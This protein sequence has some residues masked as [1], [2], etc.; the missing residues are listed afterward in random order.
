MLACKSSFSRWIAVFLAV[1]FLSECAGGIPVLYSQTSAVGDKEAPT[2]NRIAQVHIKNDSSAKGHAVLSV[3][4]SKTIHPLSAGMRGANLGNWTFFWSRPYPNDSPK[5]RELTRLIKP[6]VLRYAGGLLSNDVTWDRKNTQCYPSRMKDGVWC[7]RRYYDPRWDGWD[8]SGKTPVV[9]PGAYRLGY[10][11]DEIDA[12]AKFAKYVGAEVMIEVNITTCD[13][14]LWADMVRYANLEHDYQFKYW[15]LGNELDLARAAGKSDAPVGKE[16]VSRFKMYCRAMKA[17]D[18]SIRLVGPATAAHEEDSYFRAFKDFIDPLTRDKEIRNKRM[19]DV[20]SYHHYPLWNGGG[21]NVGYKDMFNYLHPSENRSRKH[22]NECA[23]D[24]RKML[25]KRGYQDIPIAVTEFNAIAADRLTTL[26]FNHANA[27]Y[28]A[29]TLGRQAY[30]GADMVL[31]WELYDSP[32]DVSFGLIDL[33]DSSI[34]YNSQTGTTTL[35]D[36]FTPMPVYYAYFMYAQFFGDML[37]KSSSSSQGTLSIW[38]STDSAD[39]NRLKLII[40]NLGGDAIEAVVSVAGFEPTSGKYFVMENPAFTAASDKA[41]VIDGTSINGLEIDAGSAKKIKNS[42]KA[43]TKS[44][45]TMSGVGSSFKHSF[46]AYSA[47]AIILEGPESNRINPPKRLKAKRAGGGKI[48][49]KWKDKSSNEEGFRI[50][51]KEGKNGDWEE[52]AATSANAR[53]YLDSGL[54]S[55][56]IYYYRIRAFN[57]SAAAYF[58]VYSNTASAKAK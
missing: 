24:K 38:A 3:N 46:P 41:G 36:N 5:L 44:G 49:L 30:A 27:L 21:N 17:V 52:I 22:I 28:M 16:Y 32:P 7:D 50:E 2:G 15:E 35:K 14:L 19:L 1:M 39:P 6:G 26:N 13:P 11:A 37:V 48:L 54:E 25:D 10:Q 47:T 31:H 34:T 9:V 53:K 20:L 8:R 43:I 45:R 57:G 58:S 4:A 29:D 42:A 55:S 18:D 40:V 51:R 33:N 23:A 56:K 12:L